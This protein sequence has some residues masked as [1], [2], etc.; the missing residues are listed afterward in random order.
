MNCPRGVVRGRFNQ[1]F[2]HELYAVVEELKIHRVIFHSVG[3]AIFIGP[4]AEFDCAFKC[5]YLR[6]LACVDLRFE[7]NEALC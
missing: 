5:V 2:R 7:E 3:W 4:P 6:D 1:N